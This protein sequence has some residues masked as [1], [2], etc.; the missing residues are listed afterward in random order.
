MAIQLDLMTSN[1]GISFQAAYFRVAT[2]Q[3]SKQRG[4]SFSV[5][6]DIVGYATKPITEEV[7]DIDFRRYHAPLDQI[8]AQT[9]AAFLEKVYNW[10]A[11]Q[12]DMVGAIGV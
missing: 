1:F 5:M 11:T 12:E 4:G 6:I 8:E 9:G 2:A 10:V 7:R 3:V